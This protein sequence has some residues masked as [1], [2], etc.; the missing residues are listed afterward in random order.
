MVV[1]F[2]S[3]S[4]IKDTY[5]SAPS[6]ERGAKALWGF[7]HNVT[8]F[9]LLW[10]KKKKKKTRTPRLLCRKPAGVNSD[11]EPVFLSGVANG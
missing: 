5:G 11:E 10:V 7:R 8:C 3:G 2:L 4:R 6:L 1:A 9:L